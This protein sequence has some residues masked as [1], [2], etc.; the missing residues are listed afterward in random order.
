[1]AKAYEL[2]DDASRLLLDPQSEQWAR[3][4]LLRYL[5]E[6][7]AFLVPLVPTQFSIVATLTQVAGTK[8]YLPADG[9]VLLNV[10][11]ELTTGRA[12][13]FVD[14]KSLD[15]F[16]PTWQAATPAP[17]REW[18]YD[19][20]SPQ[21]FSVSPPAIADAQLE[22]EYAAYPAALTNASDVPVDAA[23]HGALVDY[24]CARAHM[25]DADF[26]EGNLADKFYKMFMEKTGG[27]VTEPDG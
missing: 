4:E 9:A 1:M 27:V 23:Y 6:G 24:I 15:A 14:K 3:S 20:K 2:L 11:R 25:K 16:N 26:A 7:V 13:R 10:R 18:M 17:V 19:P 8:Q 21:T 22:I 12:P 5:N